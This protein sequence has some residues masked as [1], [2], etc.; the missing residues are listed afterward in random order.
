MVL[1]DYYEDDDVVSQLRSF[2]DEDECGSIDFE[3]LL[4][5]IDD[6]D[7]ESYS[8]KINGRVFLIHKIHGAVI[9]VTE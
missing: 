2:F 9:E 7:D 4:S 1:S 8:L 5:Q 6:H 3:S